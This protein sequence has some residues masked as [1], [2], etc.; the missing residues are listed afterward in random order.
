LDFQL[1]LSGSQALSGAS[2]APSGPSQPFQLP[3]SGSLAVGCQ[4]VCKGGAFNSLSRDHGAGDTL[5]GSAI[6]VIFQLP[7]S[8]SHAD[9]NVIGAEVVE[10][11]TFNSLSRDHVSHRH[12][13]SAMSESELSTP[14]LGITEPDSGIFRLSTAFCRGTSSHK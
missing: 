12:L 13:K 14:S 7:L 2:G 10:I 9:G 5:S 1:P 8:G 6:R 3:L 4:E 11:V